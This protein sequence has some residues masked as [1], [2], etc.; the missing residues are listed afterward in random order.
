MGF[1]LTEIIE[2]AITKLR[3]ATGINDRDKLLGMLAKEV[4]NLRKDY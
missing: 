2:E 1:E 4:T 3:E